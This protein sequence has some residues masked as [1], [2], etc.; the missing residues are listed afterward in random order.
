MQDDRTHHEA[1][2]VIK[3]QKWG[4]NYCER[5]LRGWF[6]CTR[7]VSHEHE[8]RN[9]HFLHTVIST[10]STGIHVSDF[11]TAMATGCDGRQGQPRRSRMLQQKVADA[12]IR[13]DATQRQS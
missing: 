8:L 7:I 2:P 11:K 3:G 12:R 6:M 10:C 13:E 5:C 4:A 9:A 1:M